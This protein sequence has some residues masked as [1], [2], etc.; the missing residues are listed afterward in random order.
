MTKEDGESYPLLSFNK[1]SFSCNKEGDFRPTGDFDGE[2]ENP[3][4]E[5]EIILDCRL[6]CFDYECYWNVKFVAER[7]STGENG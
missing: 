1:N 6:V 3:S 4:E 7:V 5:I 2:T